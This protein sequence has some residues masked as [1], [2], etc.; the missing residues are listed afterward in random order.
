MYLALPVCLGHPVYLAL[1]AIHAHP[2][3]HAGLSLPLLRW[4]PSVPSLPLLQG[5]R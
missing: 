5:Y 4:H 1:L 3:L 2:A